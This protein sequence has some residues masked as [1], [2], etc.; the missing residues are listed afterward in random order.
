MSYIPDFPSLVFVYEARAEL[1]SWVANIVGGG[2]C[3]TACSRCVATIIGGGRR[4]QGV[5]GV[6]I[7]G[8]GCCD[9]ACCRCVGSPSLAAGAA[10]LHAQGVCVNGRYS[11]K[12]DGNGTDDR[13]TCII[14]V[15]NSRQQ[16]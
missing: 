10:A 6:T 13:G 8:G 11:I 3:Y 2:C 7:I 16:P 12:S 5:C 15:S 4:V 14:N 1:L 9:I